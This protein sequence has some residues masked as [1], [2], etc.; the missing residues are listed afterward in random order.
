MKKNNNNQIVKGTNNT[1]NS[2]TPNLKKAF[3]ETN[4]EEICNFNFYA[5]DK[6][7]KTSAKMKPS[8]KKSR[9]NS[10]VSSLN[11]SVNTNHT[12]NN[13]PSGNI[14][15]LIDSLKEKLSIYENEMKELIEEKV[16]MQ[17]TINNLQISS[18]KRP[19]Q[20]NSKSP[21]KNSQESKLEEK[22]PM[23]K[24]ISNTMIKSNDSAFEINKHYLQEA[25]GL[26]KELKIL[27]STIDRQRALIEEN[28]S[29]LEESTLRENEN[30]LITE[31]NN[32]S[33]IIK[34]NRKE[35]ICNCYTGIENKTKIESD[36]IDFANSELKN[37][38]LNIIL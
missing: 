13:Q 32:D 3:E 16:Q 2:Y 25:S 28:H 12:N 35:K 34:T 29:I 26:N 8:L 15:E 30:L 33:V 14:F 17:M 4:E 31:S 1:Y 38:K 9:K 7:E 22:S 6:S 37:V 11:V 10:R 36:H 24:F 20:S 23:N 18:F 19:K 27:K 5:S 21:L